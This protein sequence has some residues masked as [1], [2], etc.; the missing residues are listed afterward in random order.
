MGYERYEAEAAV[1]LQQLTNRKKHKGISCFLVPIPTPGL[2]L[3]QKE[4][5]MGIRGS[6]TCNLIF[7]DCR[8]P[9]ENL[10]GEIGQGFKIAM[11]TL[12]SGRIGICSTSSGISQAALDCAVN[13]ASQRKA[14]GSPILNLQAI[15]V[16]KIPS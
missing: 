6:S 2:S 5:K 8:I 11:M 9:K 15:Q 14:F 7:E 10:L 13:Y 4:D 3:G 12:D 16:S 1:V